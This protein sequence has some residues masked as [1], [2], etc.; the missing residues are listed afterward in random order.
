MGLDVCPYKKILQK[1]SDLI[2]FGSLQRDRIAITSRKDKKWKN[3]LENKDRLSK[4]YKEIVLENEGN[5]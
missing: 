2:N 1:V 3:L 4:R 5:S